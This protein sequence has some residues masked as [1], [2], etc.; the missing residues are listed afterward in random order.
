MYRE[1]IT[2]RKS[3]YDF[4]SSKLPEDKRKDFIKSLYDMEVQLNTILSISMKDDSEKLPTDS[5]DMEKCMESIAKFS[6]QTLQTLMQNDSRINPITYKDCHYRLVQTIKILKTGRKKLGLDTDINK[7]IITEEGIQTNRLMI[8]I[9]YISKFDSSYTNEE[10]KQI[11]DKIL[12]SKKEIPL[13]KTIDSISF[14][15]GIAQNRKVP[16][17]FDNLLNKDDKLIEFLYKERNFDL[18]KVYDNSAVHQMIDKAYN[19]FIS[20]KAA[21]VKPKDIAVADQASR[22]TQ[23]EISNVE[24]VFRQISEIEKSSR[25]ENPEHD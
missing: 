2:N 4:L 3:F 6:Y 14:I 9:Q 13:E 18:G 19:E 21:T 8:I 15:E 7:I 16:N 22:I 20:Q 25:G 11:L 24:A 12:S 10:K 1:G 17:T 5:E 23:E